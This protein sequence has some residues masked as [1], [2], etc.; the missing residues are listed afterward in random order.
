MLHYFLWP[1]GMASMLA[2]P[3]ILFCCCRLDF[4]FFSRRLISEVS[5]S[6]VSHQTMLTQIYKIPSEIW[7]SKNIKM[8]AQFQTISRPHGEY[9]RNETKYCQTVNNTN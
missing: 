9:L 6:I 8:S 1:P 5:L 3:A 7:R 4:F 2:T